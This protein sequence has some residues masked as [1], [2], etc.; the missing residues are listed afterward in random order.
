MA[1][2][3]TV[4]ILMNVDTSE[5]ADALLREVLYGDVIVDWTYLSK[6]MPVTPIN[7]DGVCY[8][9]DCEYGPDYQKGNAFSGEKS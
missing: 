3:A 9:S 4:Q 7:K 2:I 8:P 1:Q 5:E 6:D